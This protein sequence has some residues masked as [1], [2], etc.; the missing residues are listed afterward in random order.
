MR[1][2]IV[3]VVSLLILGVTS[4]A[5]SQ[6]YAAISVVPTAEIWR[7]RAVHRWRV[8]GVSLLSASTAGLLIF[9]VARRRTGAS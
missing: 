9:L 8:A 6:M 2:L 3:V 1:T 5:I 4:L 7:A